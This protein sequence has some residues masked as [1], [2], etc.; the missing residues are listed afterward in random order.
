MTEQNPL[1][2]TKPDV[3]PGIFY[4]QVPYVL[5]VAKE[6]GQLEVLNL[7]ELIP[8]TPLSMPGLG[9]PRFYMMN[10]Q[11]VKPGPIPG[12][13]IQARKSICLNVTTLAEAM[14]IAQKAHALALEEL[15]AEALRASLSYAGM[16]GM[17]GM[18]GM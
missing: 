10:A 4:Q 1:Y 17:P 7:T 9:G 16:P 14:E 12:S 13:Q 5:H 18:P 2:T 11:V 6:D 15:E 3:V 8:V